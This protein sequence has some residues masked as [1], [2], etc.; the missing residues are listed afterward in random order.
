MDTTK[1]NGMLVMDRYTNA[2][3]RIVSIRDS[4]VFVD[5]HG[6]I[7][8]YPYPSA[9]LNYLELEDEDLQKEFFSEGLQASFD[10]FKKYYTFG[11]NSELDCFQQC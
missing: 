8:T 3:G 7:E 1:L 11:S 2:I 6:S 9:F 5:F 4:L 10:N